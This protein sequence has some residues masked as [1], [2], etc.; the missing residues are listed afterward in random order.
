MYLQTILTSIHA[1]KRF[2]ETTSEAP[3]HPTGPHADDRW[4]ASE[5]TRLRKAVE[6]VAEAIAAA[7]GELGLGPARM[8]DPRLRSWALPHASA[9]APKARR[10]LSTTLSA[11]GVGG[12]AP[13]AELLLSEVVSNA[14]RYAPGPMRLTVWLVD[15]LLRCEV[16]DRGD[17][18]PAMH[19]RSLRAP[20]MLDEGG[21]GLRLIDA[22]ACCWGSTPTTMGKA[23]WFELPAN[24]GS[25]STGHRKDQKKLLVPHA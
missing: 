18:A 19:A 7:I 4:T 25:S 12:A 15:G 1:R 13:E 10:L 5:P 2:S 14:L 3:T 23:V 17:N 9:S 11:W 21:Y 16:E 8:S 22:I 6:K 24:S 20:S